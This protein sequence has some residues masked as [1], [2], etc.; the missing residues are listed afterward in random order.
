MDLRTK[1]A[2]GD[3]SKADLVRE[4]GISR[5]TLY[6]VPEGRG[7][8]ADCVDANSDVHSEDLAVYVDGLRCPTLSG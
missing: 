8:V 5:V 1:A 2:S 4:F 7:R 6:P 3:L